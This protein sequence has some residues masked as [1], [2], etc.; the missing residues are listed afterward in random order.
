MMRY[1]VAEVEAVGQRCISLDRSCQ[2]DA[3]ETRG[4]SVSIVVMKIQKVEFSH[5]DA[6]IFAITTDRGVNRRPFH[7]E[8]IGLSVGKTAEKLRDQLE[9]R[10]GFQAA[11]GLENAVLPIVAS[12]LCI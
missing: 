10:G 12:P 3:G 6:H 4:R 1:I 11:A 8:N 9:S 7:V 5:K 2:E